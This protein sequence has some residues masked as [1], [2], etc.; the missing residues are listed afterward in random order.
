METMKGRTMKPTRIC[1]VLSALCLVHGAIAALSPEVSIMAPP[2]NENA[3]WGMIHAST[4]TLRWLWP[5]GATSAQLSIVANGSRTVLSQ[6]LADTSVTA[7]SWECGVP[8]EDTVY[9]VT[10][11]FDDSEVQTA[12]LYAL[13]GSFDL[14]VEMKGW[15]LSG[16]ANVNSGDVIPYRASW[17]DGLSGLATFALGSTSSELAYSSGYF[18]F[19]S[20]RTGL[21]TLDFEEEA[22]SPAFSRQFGASSGLIILCR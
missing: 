4:V 2:A 15:T 1:A 20:S 21:A 10:L 19:S 9:D 3:D 18:A 11:S 8:D 5:S 12:Q 14:G 22:S 16:A 17:G 13:R 7:Y 6:A